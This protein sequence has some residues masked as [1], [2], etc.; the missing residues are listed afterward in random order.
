MAAG[1]A[2]A[3]STPPPRTATAGGLPSP[4]PTVD[5]AT[6]VGGPMLASMGITTDLPPGT[7][8]PPVMH[9]VAWL[10]ADLDTG[11]VLAAKAP[12]ARLAPASTLK[13]LTSIVLLPRINPTKSY[14]A[15]AGDAR[16]GGTRIGLVPGQLYSGGQLFQA[17]LMGSANDAAYMLSRINGGIP[18]TLAEMNATA[19][20]LGA[21]DTHAGNPSGLDSPGQSS[22]AYD[23]ALFGKAAMKIAAF[24]S[25]DT[26]RTVPFPGNPVPKA[27]ATRKATPGRA[28]TSAAASSKAPVVV[29]AAGTRRQTFQLSN[30]NT[31]LFNYPGTIGGKDGYT[32]QAHRTY[33]SVARRGGHTYIVTEMGG[34]DYQQ[35]RPTARLL[36]WAFAHGPEARPIGRLVEPGEVVAAAAASAAASA[37]AASASQRA[38]SAA[39]AS[40]ASAASAMA[41]A[42]PSAADRRVAALGLAPGDARATTTTAVGAGA[43]TAA[44]LLGA[45]GL[46]RARRRMTHA[47]RH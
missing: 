37:A 3:A 9:D 14:A 11:D 16:A 8:A 42:D 32:D 27:S 2:Q 26:A 35:W 25:Y 47:A 38:D 23:L 1:P 39:S 28:P 17:L 12:H 7:P 44:L 30:H 21:L 43:L 33:I 5:P 41:A 15:A 13:T 22:S 34:T 10:V 6:A 24:R 4:A 46:R 19:K 45:L 36:D 29:D 31:L 20:R 40:A 18:A